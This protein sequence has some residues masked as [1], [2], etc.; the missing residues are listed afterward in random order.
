[1]YFIKIKS[2]AAILLRVI[3]NYDKMN[4]ITILHFTNVQNK[5]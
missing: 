5:C 2:R 1:M 3:P 4:N